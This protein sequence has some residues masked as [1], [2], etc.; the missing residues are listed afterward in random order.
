M[1]PSSEHL[2]YASTNL[3]DLNDAQAGNRSALNHL[4]A[5]IC[6][7]TLHVALALT[8]RAGKRDYNVAQDI[9][10]SANIDVAKAV[11]SGR[12]DRR[13]SK[14]HTFSYTVVARKHVDWQ[15][16]ASRESKVLR[17]LSE[18]DAEREAESD[19]QLKTW[20]AVAVLLALREM[21]KACEVGDAQSVRDFLI[22]QLHRL[23]KL[24]GDEVAERFEGMT[25][26]N[27]RKIAA[28][29]NKRMAQLAKQYLDRLEDGERFAL[30]AMAA[31]IGFNEEGM[32]GLLA[33]IVQNDDESLPDDVEEQLGQSGSAAYEL[34]IDPTYQR[35]STQLTSAVQDSEGNF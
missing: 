34:L 18:A 17:P 26:S 14:L 6:E 22:F 35:V 4:M 3:K 21:R 19:D 8:A 23:D 12:F 33:K 29:H 13:K 28:L 1:D 16:T 27:V 24:S 32:I 15:R 10:Q 30:R 25:A 2:M 11:A 20:W 5:P 9:A 31:G 7:Y